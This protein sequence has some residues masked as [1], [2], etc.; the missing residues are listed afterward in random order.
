M[1]GLTTVILL[2]VSNIFMTIAWYGHLRFKDDYCFMKWSI[3][4]IVGKT[5]SQVVVVDKESTP[6]QQLFLIFDDCTSLEIYGEYFDCARELEGGGLFSVL[7]FVGRM[8]P[9]EV[10]VYP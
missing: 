8:G 6:K 7:E 3:E 1:K 2:I 5:I 9:K 4:Q 10:T